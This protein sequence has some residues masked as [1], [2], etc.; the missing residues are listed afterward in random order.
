M[1]APNMASPPTTPPA[2]G[3]ARLL[4]FE[5]EDDAVD[6]DVE[7]V[8]AVEDPVVDPVV[9][10][11]PPMRV[12]SYLSFGQDTREGSPRTRKEARLTYKW[13]SQS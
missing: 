4:L 6:V 12:S 5:F 10:R 2:M 9:P 13:R 3:P 1:K 11:A 8:V 7:E